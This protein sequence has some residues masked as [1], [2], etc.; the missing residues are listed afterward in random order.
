MSA[1]LDPLSATDAPPAV[2]G[3]V[4]AFD[5]LAFVLLIAA[6]FCCPLDW[7]IPGLMFGEPLPLADV[8]LLAALLGLLPGAMSGFAR[9]GGVPMMPLFAGLLFLLGGVVSLARGD[10]HAEPV[11]AATLSF[12]LGIFPLMLMLAVREDLH[13]LDWL[14]AAW[15]A[16]A[17]L[18]AS[19]ALA[20]RYG[21]ALFGYLD[22]ASAAGARAW[23]LS[24]HPNELGYTSALTVPVAIYLFLRY[25][26]TWVRLA[27]VGVL[28][29]LIAGVQLS[30]SRSS[31]WALVLGLA[32]P[33]LGVISARRLPVYLFAGVGLLATTAL[34]ATLVLEFNLP[35]AAGIEESALGRA[36]GL[37]PSVVE[38]DSGRAQFYAYSWAQFLDSPLFGQG[39]GWLRTAHIH[40]LALLHAG[41]LLGLLALLVWLAGMAV[42]AANVMTGLHLITPAGARWLWPTSLAGLIIWFANGAFQ[43]I[44]TD[45]NGYILAAA[46][47]IL[48][49]HVR[50]VRWSTAAAPAP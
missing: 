42:A 8:F 23:G 33:V 17:V 43:P 11:T 37:S 13:R 28:V 21:I 38:S 16:G 44:L 15:V 46:L 50:R 30:G 18:T 49:G 1:V 48:D 40:V 34:F 20:S 31:F 22:Q 10:L 5:R 2:G 14:L 47:L 27:M 24:Y 12:A 19:V 7:A 45:R 41:G 36:L 6:A 9:L 32:V 35:I 25:R 39:W 29:T 4:A 3:A 26:S